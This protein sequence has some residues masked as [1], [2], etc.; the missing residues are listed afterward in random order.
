MAIKVERISSAKAESNELFKIFFWLKVITNKYYYS[1][2][3]IILT[4]SWIW[5][6]NSEKW[7]LHRIMKSTQPRRIYITFHLNWESTS[8]VE[9]REKSAAC[10]MLIRQTYK[11]NT[12]EPWGIHLFPKPIVLHVCRIL[13]WGNE[14]FI[15]NACSQFAC[16]SLSVRFQFSFIFDRWVWNWGMKLCLNK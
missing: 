9:D 3:S 2:F 1:V 5:N 13:K 10:W 8:V 7:T 16:L 14:V 12:H 4:W 6:L 15:I 11:S